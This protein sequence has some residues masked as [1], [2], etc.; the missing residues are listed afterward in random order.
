MWP[1][2]MLG[3]FVA[4]IGIVTT[5]A[6]VQRPAEEAL[7]SDAVALNILVYD[8]AAAAFATLDPAF[9]GEIGPNQVADLLPSGYVNLG[10]WRAHVQ[11]RHMITAPVSSVRFAPDVADALAHY[12]YGQV[13]VGRMSSRDEAYTGPLTCWGFVSPQA[14]CVPGTVYP[15]L[16]TAYA[17]RG[18][19]IVLRKL[20]A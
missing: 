12:S 11:A 6:R 9:E 14:T 3:A 7:A 13:L 10:G 19:P 18:A 2:F 8:R 4:I 17:P 15:S 1:L 16:I 20:G 5:S